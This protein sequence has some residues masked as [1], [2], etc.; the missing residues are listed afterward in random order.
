MTKIKKVLAAL[1]AILMIFSSVSALAYAADGTAG[2]TT[3]T[4]A[5]KFF[6][7]VN[8]SWVETRRAGPGETVKARVYLGTDYFSNT[9]NLL[10]FY[11]KDFFTHSYSDIFTVEVNSESDFVKDNEVSGFAATGT[12]LSIGDLETNGY[13]DSG[14]L[15]KHGAFSV[16]LEIG[17]DRNVKYSLDTWLFEFTLKVADDATGEG[18]LFVVENTVRS[19][20]RQTAKIDVPRGNSNGTSMDIESMAVWNPTVSVSSQPV[21]VES[22]LT[23]VAKDA[24]EVIGDTVFDG[25]IGTAVTAPTVK[26]DGYTFAGWTNSEGEVVEAPTEIPVEDLTLTASW[27]KNV[28]VTFDT[29]GGSVIDPAP[30]TDKTPGTALTAPANPTKTGYTFLGWMDADGAEATIPTIFPTADVTYTAKWAL[31]VT[32]NFIVD[33]ETKQTFNGY[34]GQEFDASQVN[35]PSKEGYYFIGWSNAVPA[36][37]PEASTDYVA[38]WDIKTYVV[39][40]YIDGAYI[41]SA[42][43]PYGGA[44]STKVPGA[45]AP[46]GYKLTGWYTDSACTV[47]FDTS[48]VMGTES[49]TLYSKTEK[50]VYSSTFNAAGGKFDGNK[51]E[52][53][54]DTAFGEKVIAPNPPVLTGYTFAGWSPDVGFMDASGGKTYYATWVAN[55]YNVAYYVNGNPYETLN[56]AFGESLEVPGDPSLEGRTF[57]GWAASADST[58]IVDP[59]TYVMNEVGYSFYAVFSDNTYNAIFYL[60]EQDK[61]N[62]VVFTTVPT[63]YDKQ[64]AAPE[65]SAREGYTFAAWSPVPG[66]MPAN[67]AEFVGTWT[68][69]QYTITFDENGG[70]SVADITDDYGADVSSPETT[71]EGHTFVGWFEGDSET[72]FE[73]NTMPARNVNLKAHWSP[74]EYSI[75]FNSMDGTPV[76]PIRDNY[77]EKVEKPENPTKTG[78][79]FVDWFEEGSDTAFV[80][81]TMPARNVTLIAKWEAKTF[82]PGVKFNANGGSWDD[83]TE[84]YVPAT[85][86]AEISAPDS[87]PARSGYDFLGWSKSSAATSAEAL[88]TLNQEITE[89]SGVEFFA[90]WKAETYVDGITFNADGGVFA[91]GEPTAK[92]T[93]TYGE[94]IAAPVAPTREGYTFGGWAKEANA[95]TGSL[96]LGTLDV[97]LDDTTLTY[98]AVWKAISL[99]VKFDANTGAYANG[100]TT[101]DVS[102]TYDQP[103]ESP[104]EE[105]VKTGHTFK[106][107]AKSPTATDALDSLGNLTQ[108]TAPTFY[109]VWEKETYIGKI[110]FNA[111]GGTFADGDAPKSIDITFNDPIVAPAEP[112]RAGY[113]FKGW[114]TSSSALSGTKELG[115][116]TTDLSDT[117][118]T[119]YAVWEVADGVKYTVNVY[120]MN[121][122]GVYGEPETHTS[123]GVTGASISSS[124]FYTLTNGLVLDSAYATEQREGTIAANGSTVLEVHIKRNSYKFTVVIDGVATDTTY[125]YDAI[126]TAPVAPSKTGYTFSGWTGDAIPD[127]MPANNVRVVANYTI[128][129]HTITYKVDGVQSGDVETKDYNTPIT[130]RDIPFKTGYTFSGWTVEIGGKAAS[131][132]A[133]MPDDDIVVSGSFTVDTHKASFY[134][135]GKLYEE[136]E[137]EYGKTPVLTKENPSKTGYI[138]KGW[139]PKLEEMGTEDI[140]YDA[141]FEADTVKYKVEVYTMGLD[142]KYGEPETTELTNTADTTA[143]YTPADKI[144]FTVSKDSVL[145]GNTEPN[146]SLVLKVYYERNKYKLTTAVD[147][148]ESSVSYYYGATIAKPQD[149]PKE[150]YTFVNWLDEKGTPYTFGT[151]PAN[152]VKVTANFRINQ[153]TI[154][155]ESEGGSYVAP[156]T[157]NYATAVD[158]PDEPTRTGYTFGGWFEENSDTKYEFTTM[159]ARNVT[160]YAKWTINQYTITFVTDGGT[161]IEPITQDYGTV[162]N[163]P[164]NP[165]K[166]GYAFKGWDTAV[167]ST[168]PAKNVTITAQWQAETYTP[169]IKFEANGGSWDDATYK[170]VPATFD[171]DIAEPETDPERAGYNFLGWAKTDDAKTA[172]EDLGKLTTDLDDATLTYYAVWAEADGVKYTVQVYTQGTDGSYALTS[173]N[174]QY[175]KTGSTVTVEGFYTVNAG[176]EHNADHADAVESG[177]IAPDGNTVLKVYIA[178]KTYSATFE[179]FDEPVQAL[180][181]AKI[182][183][184]KAPEVPGSRFIKWVD[185]DGNALDTMPIGGAAF[186]PVYETITYVINYYVDGKL[187]GNYR[188]SSGTE[189]P[190]AYVG[191]T[192]P[193]GYDFHGWFTDSAMTTA[194]KAGATVQAADISL[195]G[196]T[197]AKMVDVVFKADGGKFADGSEE[198][199][200][201]TAFDS[202]I[203]AP[204]APTRDGYKFVGW[205]REVA[206][207]DTLTPAPYVATWE[208]LEYKATFVAGSESEEFTFKFGEEIDMPADPESEGQIFAGWYDADGKKLVAGTTMPA[209]D[210]TYT[211]RFTTEEPTGYTVTFYQYEESVHGPEGN[212]NPDF[213]PYG[214]QLTDVKAG[215]TIALPTAPTTVNSAHY[216][217][218]GWVDSEGNEYATGATMPELAAGTTELKLYPSYSRIT[219]K[220]VPVAGQKTVIERNTTEG[221]IKEQL[222]DKS[223]TDKRY[224]A[225]ADRNG[226]ADYSKWF[227]YGLP[228]RRLRPADIQNLV[229][230]DVVGDGKVVITPVNGT[231]YGTGAVV[232]VYDCVT[233]TDVLVEQFYIIY[234]GDLDGDARIDTNDSSILKNEVAGITNWSNLRRGTSYLIKAADLDA[235]TKIDTNDSGLLKSYVSGVRRE[236]DQVAGVIL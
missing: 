98:H 70:T 81:S 188:L 73:F 17:T 65:A 84:K 201:P 142:G 20:T 176:F 38:Q 115:T 114:S 174:S 64:I 155:F 79:N 11:D 153:Y 28:T 50:Q 206:M 135:D 196:Y 160:L 172:I 24:T 94:A 151:M 131:F 47:P 149:P 26:R 113:T 137:T 200:V 39:K 150:G 138:F 125:F 56:V 109:A 13:L 29:D 224:T 154:T 22:T 25:V 156:I 219:V 128:N 177:T 213:I 35:E 42:R 103:I 107:W 63:V 215:D 175:G 57:E 129:K 104:A 91:D 69:N 197:T 117:S 30:Y 147:G 227:I 23:F 205:S 77:G 234:F 212:E 97:D 36:A 87:D 8:G 144:G 233:G 45:S 120:I 92:V 85:F 111:N 19:T 146:G 60:T 21:S 185:A 121:T 75:E 141:V 223:V 214:D 184:P 118:I 12:M 165:T 16:Y 222:A 220:L 199:T 40:Y 159:P 76:S 27:V 163:A 167:P 67:D 207:L 232:S 228:N 190:T 204:E 71:K 218:D 226:A 191:Y 105:P 1:L 164:A 130:I 194:L 148:A 74:N 43:V 143:T 122:E 145:S 59:S 3:V 46:E 136:V 10:F 61:A 110:T 116:L 5:T 106:G 82:T 112:T 124:D 236:I 202:Q 189:I 173:S 31:N 183:A 158:T 72:A 15:A 209:K 89:T 221:V 95:Q 44:I 217:F 139:N 101:A 178:R 171:A 32:M 162:V 100:L 96:N 211:A 9:S 34:A 169:G 33:G 37:Y 78:Y 198:M 48:T 133:T 186:T 88:G 68:I 119:Y 180:Y 127:K 54:V 58:D 18:D 193:E 66:K 41:T 235:S 14:F 179:G 80:F 192:V 134:A 86:N 210:V 195:Y 161:E 216:T 203:V 225:V 168:M 208:A 140:R 230:F 170:Y 99:T 132:P 62:G 231:G 123:A 157:Q 166:T 51:D 49:V 108:V 7:E 152:D 102:A 229:Y 2:G 55:E 126:V 52:V 4:F 93:A 187:E 83:E 181:G 182:N 6:K 90:V 53:T